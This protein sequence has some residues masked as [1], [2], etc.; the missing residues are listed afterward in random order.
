MECNAFVQV[1]D[2]TRSGKWTAV[3]GET[4]SIDA[5]RALHEMGN[6]TWVVWEYPDGSFHGNEVQ[7][8][9][10]DGEISNL[11]RTHGSGTPGYKIRKSSLRKLIDLIY[12]Q[13]TMDL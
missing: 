7:H 12:K 11:A 13:Q 10:I 3:I 5:C 9:I 2:G 4:D 6:T 1:K 8:L